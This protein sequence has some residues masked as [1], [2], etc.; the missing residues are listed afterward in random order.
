[1]SLTQALSP[2]GHCDRGQAVPTAD[3]HEGL[4]AELGA[5]SERRRVC[6]AACAVDGRLRLAGDPRDELPLEGQLPRPVL[7]DPG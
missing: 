3:G 4:E 7:P 1:L 2:L 5:C 6:P